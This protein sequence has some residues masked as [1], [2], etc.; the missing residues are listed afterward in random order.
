MT[1]LGRALAERI[2]RDG[3]LTVAEYMAL[4]LDDPDAQASKDI[5]ALAAKL[6]GREVPATPA[7]ESIR[8][9]L[10]GRKVLR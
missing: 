1:P 5:I 2:R 9:G 6:V 7:E 4:C 10:F 8:R 3:P